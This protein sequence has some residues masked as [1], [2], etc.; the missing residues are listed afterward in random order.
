VAGDGPSQEGKAPARTR[1]QKATDAA[2]F[3]GSLCQLVYYVL[4]AIW[5]R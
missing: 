4:R 3:V 2:R 1:L 5:E